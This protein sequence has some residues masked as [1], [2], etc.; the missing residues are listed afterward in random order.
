MG[1]VPRPG[2]TMRTV[3]WALVNAGES[4]LTVSQL[5]DIAYPGPSTWQQREVH[6]FAV[7]KALQLLAEQYVHEVRIVLDGTG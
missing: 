2:K 7:R 5:V 6:R 1:Y 3:H 4:W